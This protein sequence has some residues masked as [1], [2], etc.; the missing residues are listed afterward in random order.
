MYN[1]Q[2]WTNYFIVRRINYDPDL[3]RGKSSD[4]KT[5]L[6]ELDR[7][8]GHKNVI[9]IRKLSMDRGEMAHLVD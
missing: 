4:V 6:V 9:S 8:V 5:K 1:A 2:Y 7:K 3:T